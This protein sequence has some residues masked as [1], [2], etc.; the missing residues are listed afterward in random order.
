MSNVIGICN[1]HNEPHLGEI[2]KNR[3]LAALSFLGRYGI[4]DFTLSNDLLREDPILKA[5]ILIFM[6][7]HF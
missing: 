4:I 3:P 1:L 7:E 6:L 5:T 2:T